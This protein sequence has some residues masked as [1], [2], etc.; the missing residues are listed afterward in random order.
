MQ[1]PRVFTTLPSSAEK[2]ASGVFVGQE[3]AFID[4]SDRDLREVAFADKLLAELS[5]N[6]GERC[7]VPIRSDRMLTLPGIAIRAAAVP[8]L[9][10]R[11]L[12]TDR[13]LYRRDVDTVHALVVDLD[14][15]D[16]EVSLVVISAGAEFDR[17][18]V[19]L[20]SEGVAIVKFG[21][22]PTG[23][24]KLIRGASTYL[25]DILPEQ[26]VCS[27]TVAGFEF[28]PLVATLE[29][30]Q[31]L[32]QRLSVELNLMR[33][34]TPFSGDVRVDLM[35]GSRRIDSRLV[36][37][38]QGVAG[39]GLEIE[40]NGPHHLELVLTSDRSATAT[41]PLPGSSR[42]DREE[43]VLSRCGPKLAA[44]LL[45]GADTTET[46]GLHV[47]ELSRTEAPL[48]I[49]DIH[50]ETARLIAGQSIEAC[51]VTVR[52]F[53][54]S[55]G[56]VR[57]DLGV[58]RLGAIGSGDEFEIELPEG[59][60]LLSVGGFV[61]GKPW[62]ARA[63]T[64]RP[65]SCAA[66]IR[67]ASAE[68]PMET[69]RRFD[70]GSAVKIEV[71]TDS[72]SDGFA[73]VTVRDAR[74][75]P[76]RRPL[77]T[78]AGQI[79]EAAAEAEPGFVDIQAVGDF[80]T[81]DHPL[82]GHT[83]GACPPISSEIL[84]K[85]VEQQVIT[86]EQADDVL[87]ADAQRSVQYYDV[88]VQKG[89]A[90]AEAI[91]RV[92]AGFYGHDHVDLES[93]P[94]DPSVVELCPESVARE[95]CVF[96]L[97]EEESALHVV[98]SNPV[99]LETI[100]KLRFILNRQIVVSVATPATI[101]AAIDANYEYDEDSNYA[102]TMLQEFTDTAIDFT[103]T[104]S[105]HD[106]RSESPATELPS[107]ASR[108]GAVEVTPT[109]DDADVLCCE[110]VEIRQ[111]LAA[112][113]VTLP[114][115]SGRYSV[116]VF[117]VSQGAWAQAET[118]L[119]ADAEPFVEL[120]LPENLYDGDQSVGRVVARCDSGRFHIEVLR[121]GESVPLFAAGAK[122]DSIPDGQVFAGSAELTFVVEQGTYVATVRQIG[123]DR[124][125]QTKQ[126][127][128][129]LG[130]SEVP[131]RVLR[132]LSPGETVRIG[133]EVREIRLLPSCEPF[134]RMSAEATAN[135]EHLCCE[136]TAAKL[137]ASFVCLAGAIAAGQT[138]EPAL[139]AIRAGLRRE[140]EMWLPHQGFAMYPGSA[141]YRA[142]GEM[143]ALHLAKIELVREFVASAPEGLV[144]L[145]ET[146]RLSVMANRFYGREL[147]PGDWKTFQGAY[148][149]A[150]F[151]P[152]QIAA[153]SDKALSHL[154]IKKPR[155][156]GQSYWREDRAY[157]LA[158]LLF[159]GEIEH[160]ERA[161]TLANELFDDLG[162]QGR[163]YSTIDST[164]LIVMMLEMS[165]RCL[166]LPDTRMLVNDQLLEIGQKLPAETII[167]SLRCEAGRVAA[168]LNC[169]FQED[170]TTL[171]SNVPISVRLK[172]LGRKT[173]QVDVGSSLDL[174]VTLDDGYE[175]GD[176]IW[177]ALPPALSRLEGGGQVKQFAIDPKGESDV[178]VRLAATATTYHP[179]Q[180]PA[181]Q[182]FVV[183]LRNMY[184][185]QRIGTQGLI[186]IRV[187][188][189]VR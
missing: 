149:G 113:E 39:V 58:R 6:E 169:R 64:L 175:P 4:F 32:G 162:P 124:S 132:L 143:A 3:F 60:G 35:D 55:D 104:M 61:D 144:L 54:G 26:D 5:F 107:A 49:H 48:Q 23:S 51:C 170:W 172:H 69:R 77:P 22:L 168:E 125:R 12:T 95:N 25:A 28:A 150:R 102:D 83:R 117:V 131:R 42:G 9:S 62:E 178:V 171:K 164:A 17:R 59:A 99:D 34:G 160:V 165:R 76:S 189:G 53:A 27:F 80:C 65:S 84:A 127:V 36:A 14:A 116:D 151:D 112:T 147:S 89:Y 85:M 156:Y 71:A 38:E 46:L 98:M 137:F 31:L 136:Q 15:P 141:P 2:L 111:G 20:N 75:Q 52:T 179:S 45:P 19:R 79:K 87:G 161:M 134:L 120:Q 47:R 119:T 146:R 33:F 105:L 91:A 130:K 176:L 101:C 106:W 110:L 97:R 142:L 148:M 154:R 92:I 21:E 10:L 7:V 181:E 184:E 43:T 72:V 108:K 188:G 177:I 109:R 90:D 74:L 57:R 70:P 182:H 145:E 114:D 123:N 40:G 18:V 11:S 129:P 133:E 138:T 174:H 121:N 30:V 94:D 44:S 128:R 37:A 16:S 140:R 167:N 158:T 118:L 88:L 159:A 29:Q 63:I 86:Q 139:I 180:E 73:A 56:S 157:A 81:V 1:K 185:E 115:R 163:L 135:Y 96:P 93:M 50:R 173:N 183:C 152:K 155:V 41:I 100:D 67:L 66:S 13:D 126:V 187:D 8:K 153:A 68:E 103:D 122:V 82:R 24:Y 186:P 166:T 78:L